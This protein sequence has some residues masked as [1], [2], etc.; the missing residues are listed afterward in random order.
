MRHTADW[1]AKAVEEWAES[2][3]ASSVARRHGV[4]ERTLI[5]WRSELR[6]RARKAAKPK[7]RLLPV[8]VRAAPSGSPRSHAD[9]FEV[10]V[11]VGATR[12]TIRG[13]VSADHL[14]AIM[15]ASV[16]AC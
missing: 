2:G 15:M 10:F 6:R 12:M 5:W 1:W 9:E 14:A 13:A 3:D 11:E 7:P 16:R 8:V 4:R